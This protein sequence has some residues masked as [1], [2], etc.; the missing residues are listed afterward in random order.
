MRPLVLFAVVLLGLPFSGCSGT[1]LIWGINAGEGVGGDD[2]DSE[3]PPEFDFSRYDG[4]EYINIDW[5]QQFEQQGRED[6][7]APWPTTGTETTSDDQNLC[8]D[9]DHIWLVEQEPGEGVEACYAN[10]QFS[11]QPRERRVGIEIIDDVNF[12]FWRNSEDSDN[13]LAE[14]GEG[15]FLG[16]EFTW[17]GIDDHSQSVGDQF[18]WWYSGEGEF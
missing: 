17:S 14:V 13:P 6:C 2:D 1:L 7:R 18:E 11:T 12:V 5:A 10:T 3:L 8:P 9:C 16:S 15:A 4:V